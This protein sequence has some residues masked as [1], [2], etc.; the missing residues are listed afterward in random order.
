MPQDTRVDDGTC[1]LVRHAHEQLRLLV[2]AGYFPVVIGQPGHVEVRGLTGDFPGAH[3]VVTHADV[4]TLP[5]T[6]VMASSHKR[7]NRSTGSGS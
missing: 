2:A 7:P 6:R 1:P 3:V 4:L 5:R